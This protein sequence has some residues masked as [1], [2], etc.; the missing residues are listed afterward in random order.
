MAET[1]SDNLAALRRLTEKVAVELVYA[2]PGKDD[3]LLPINALLSEMEALVTN[4]PLWPAA[5]S[6]LGRSRQV[7]DAVLAQA[8]FDSADLELLSEWL[9]WM[10]T[11]LSLAEAGQALPPIPLRFVAPTAPGPAAPTRSNDGPRAEPQPLTPSTE[12]PLQ[13]NLEGDADLLREFINESDEHLQ[14]IELG[15]LTL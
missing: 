2:A 7:V 4:S 10:Q 5:A 3:G 6:I 13:M 14:H 9:G 1:A 11:A 15:V 12:E 8:G